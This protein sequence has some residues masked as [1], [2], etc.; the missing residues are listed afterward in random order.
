LRS[1][2]NDIVALNAINKQRTNDSRF[3]F[4]FITP[5]E[6][7]LY[8]RQTVAKFPFESFVWLLWSVKEAAYKYQK[9]LNPGLVFSPVNIIVTKIN[10]P[11]YPLKVFACDV[12][13][14]DITD[15]EFT[16]GEVYISGNLLF[17]KSVI[18]D[19][20]IASFVGD[21]PL[22]ANIYCGIKSIIEPSYQNQSTSVRQFL[23]NKLQ[24]DKPG[25]QLTIQKTETG[26]PVLLCNNIDTSALISFAHHH[27]FIAYIFKY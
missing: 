19:D 2:G 7:A 17:F 12:W 8:Q 9:R 21:D 23:I 25:T 14:G 10:I 4:K 5:A 11:L 3:H 20:L 16:F 26:Y 27:V 22:F 13:E 6:L 15:N 18:Q 1:I 24:T